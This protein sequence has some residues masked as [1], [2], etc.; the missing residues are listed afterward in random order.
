MNLTSLLACIPYHQ[1]ETIHSL[2]TS[3]VEQSRAGIL[4]PDLDLDPEAQFCHF[5]ALEDLWYPHLSLCVPVSSSLQ[6]RS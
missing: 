5:L 1:V 4:E 3:K 6:L 2:Y